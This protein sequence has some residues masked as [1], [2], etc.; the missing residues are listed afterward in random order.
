MYQAQRKQ[1]A[2][3]EHLEAASEVFRVLKI[4]KLLER[5]ERYA[6]EFGLRSTA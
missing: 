6:G 2:A 3:A 1:K 5:A 4:P